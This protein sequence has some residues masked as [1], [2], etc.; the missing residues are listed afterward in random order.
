MKA[1]MLAGG[2]GTRLK[3]VTGELPKPLV[4]LLGRPLMEY[5]LLLLREHGFTDVCAAVRYRAED[6]RRC[7]GDGSRLGLRLSYR[8][9]KDFWGTAGAV[10]RCRDFIGGE[11]VLILSGDA[12]CDL[13]LSA[14]MA[15]HRERQAAATVALCRRADPLRFGLAVT[16]GEGWIRAFVEKPDWSRVVTDQVST[17]IYVLSPR[18]VDAIAED[19]P[20]DFARDL[21][22]ALLECGEKLLGLPMEGYWRD[23]GTPLSYYRCCVDALEGKLRLPC[24]EAFLPPQTAEER[25]PDD[26]GLALDCPCGSRAA[27]MGVLSEELLSLGPDLSDGLRLSGENWRLHIAPLSGSSALR[28]CVQSPDAE[29]ARS[30]AFSARDLIAAL[31]EENGKQRL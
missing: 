4:P 18:A 19:R 1:I 13:D 6:I 11:D 29:F 25:S 30:L 21:F 2:E 22:P 12:A 10:R 7:F 27:V 8:E 23:V 31:G 24:D 15:A 16:D 5:G 28:V 17:G 9:E 3:P 20:S 14:L 26:E